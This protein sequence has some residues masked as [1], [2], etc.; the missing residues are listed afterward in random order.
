MNNKVLIFS[1]PSG[2]GKTTIVR[3]LLDKYPFLEFSVS[4]TSRLPRG[5]EVNGHDYFFLD[6]TDFVKRIEAGNFVEYEEVYS[7]SFYGTLKS[8]VERIWLAGKIVVF[9]I[10]VKGG[11]NLKKLYGHSALAVFVQPPSI[12]I[13]RERLLARGTDSADTIDK[14][15]AKANEELT[16]A[17]Y[18][19]RVLVNENLDIC[20][21]E[22][23]KLV[24]NFYSEKP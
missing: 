17:K 15:V 20:L 12:N 3:H 14:R 5:E 8:E 23:E 6:K 10:D 24:E 13:L 11:V 21:K 1:A 18:F 19:D 4:A 22:A 2:A 16:F 7:G 9:D